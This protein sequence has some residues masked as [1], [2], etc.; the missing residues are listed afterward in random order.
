MKTKTH[1]DAVIAASCQE[2][3]REEGDIW[4]HWKIHSGS[5]K[6]VAHFQA[7]A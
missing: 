6:D 5:I 3:E 4:L 2:E 7:L 1:V